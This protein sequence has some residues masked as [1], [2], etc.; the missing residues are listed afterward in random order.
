MMLLVAGIAGAQT[1]DSLYQGLGGT[2][3]IEAIAGSLIDRVAAD[4]VTGPAFEDTRRDRIKRLLAEQICELSGGPCRYSGDSMKRSHAGLKISEAMFYRMV[5]ILRD[6]LHE[7]HVDQRSIN[8]LLRLLAPM[9]RDIV[10]HPR[11]AHG[12]VPIATDAR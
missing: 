12:T 11:P 5:E 9:K 8:A 6:V 1:D 7:R 2:S 10:E 4:P 3:G